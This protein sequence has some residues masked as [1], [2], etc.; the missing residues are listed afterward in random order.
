MCIHNPSQPAYLLLE[1]TIEFSWQKNT[2]DGG[3]VRHQ[4]AC[5]HCQLEADGDHDKYKWWS[6]WKR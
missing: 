3:S 1:I 4:E 2:S 5:H 6:T